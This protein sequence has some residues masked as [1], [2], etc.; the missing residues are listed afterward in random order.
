[1]VSRVMF[2][3]DICSWIFSLFSFVE[4]YLES[5]FLAF[6]LHTFQTKG[7]NFWLS[8]R[9]GVPYLSIELVNGID[10]LVNAHCIVLSHPMTEVRSASDM[11]Q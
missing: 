6:D 10:D 3:Y 8:L 5:F 1:M 7:Y 4:W 2:S 11:R 9:N